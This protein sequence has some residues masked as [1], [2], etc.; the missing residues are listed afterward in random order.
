MVW[1]RVRKI[2]WVRVKVSD[3]KSIAFLYYRKFRSTPTEIKNGQ[4]D[5]LAK[6]A[7]KKG[8]SGNL[9]MLPLF[10]KMSAW[11]AGPN[12][13]PSSFLGCGNDRVGSRNLT[14]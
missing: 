4:K 12:H 6:N 11:G 10:N 8:S 3:E 1:L 5:L 13:Q 7:G 2:V 9:K 14:G